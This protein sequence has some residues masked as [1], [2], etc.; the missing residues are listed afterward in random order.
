MRNRVGM[1]ES[2]PMCGFSISIPLNEVGN[3]G[4]IFNE[5]ENEV[6][7]PTRVTRLHRH[8]YL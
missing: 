1:E 4:K 3:E 8:P 5:V 2:F 7:L 6:G